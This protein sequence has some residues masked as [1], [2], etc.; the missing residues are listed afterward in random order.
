MNTK[1][2]DLKGNY[3]NYDL[4]VINKG[5]SKKYTFEDRL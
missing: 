1:Y 2:Y 4:F 5:G 3:G